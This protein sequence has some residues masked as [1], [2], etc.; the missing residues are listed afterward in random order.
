MSKL[1]PPDP[2]YES[3]TFE[4]PSTVIQDSKIKRRN[5]IQSTADLFKSSGASSDAN[6]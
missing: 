2:K 1:K 3:R 4:S 6:R 5:K